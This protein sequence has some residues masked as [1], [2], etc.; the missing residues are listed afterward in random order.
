MRIA[1]ILFPEG[2][3]KMIKAIAGILCILLL[4]M[5]TVWAADDVTVTLRLDR[6]EAT[7][8]DTLRMEIHVSGS[9]KSDAPPFL[10]GLES[11]L[12]TNGGTSSRMEFINGK[13]NS[14][15]DYTYF[16]Q[17]RKTGEFKIGPVKV[18]VDGKIYE[19]GSQS[20]VVRTASQ[21]GSSDRGPV[22]IQASISS[23][24]IF[25][26]EQ[27]LYTLKL[28][29]RVNIGNLS[30][31][32]PEMEYVSFHQLGRPLE[33]QSTDEGRTYQVLEI[34]HAMMVSKQGDFII[35]PSRLKLTVRQAG[36]RSRLG[37]FFN[38]SFSGFSSNRPLT[39]TTDPINLHVNPLPKEG[40]P[41]D[42]TGL[43]GTFQVASTLE[44]SSLKAGES[45]T[46]TIQVKGRGTVNR[47]PDLDLPEM[48][49]ARTYSDQPVLET[50]QSR[51][52]IRGTKTMKWALVPENTGEYKVPLLS[53]SFFNPET[54]KYHVLVTPTHY[55]SVL[56]GK[57]EES[58]A[59]LNSLSDKNNTGGRTNNK[60]IQQLGEDI[61]P[62]HTDA[63]DLSVPFRFLSMGWVLWFV[64]V[65]PLFIYLMLLGA[66]RVQRLSPERLAQSISKKAFSTLKKRCQKDQISYEDLINAFKDY[67]NDRCSLSIGTL[68]ADD[69]EKILRDQGVDAETAKNMRSLVQ[70]FETAV[71]AGNHFND[72]DAVGELLGLARVIEKGIS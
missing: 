4:P 34:R 42:F 39:L 52:G 5:F 15:I 48:D 54:K 35:T 18:N 24:D 60:E 31:G 49:F 55:L 38:D 27:V 47:I 70:R 59:R 44:P 67:L 22:F 69:A 57:S 28:Y 25:V 13:V 50:E 41:A 29:Y 3:G 62:I 8:S 56:P 17:P 51:Q 1:K 12:V 26:D 40:R 33:Y 45:A 46:L 61:L 30:L 6:V 23:Q 36:S 71:Y 72:S 9:R 68:T 43:V 21:P 11:F 10:H 16:I 32:L 14:G 58:V 65:G 66:L 53:L 19:S 20:L 63:V 2:T 37:N 64:L 7:L